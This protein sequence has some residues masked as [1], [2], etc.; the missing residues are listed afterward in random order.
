MGKIASGEVRICGMPQTFATEVAVGRLRFFGSGERSGERCIVYFGSE[1]S[2]REAV[3]LG[4]AYFFNTVAAAVCSLDVPDSLLGALSELGTPYFLLPES[5]SIYHGLE[6]RLALLDG[7][8]GELIIDPQLETLRGYTSSYDGRGRISGA[9]KSRFCK[10]ISE[11][12]AQAGGALCDCDD[13]GRGGELFEN[14]SALAEE[15][16][17]SSLTVLLSAPRDSSEEAEERFCNSAEALFRAAVYGNMSLLIGGICSQNEAR[18]AF[19]L[20]HGCFCRLL[21]EG[22]EFNGYIAKGIL[23]SS[24]VLLLDVSRLPRCDLLC[25]DFSLLSAR[26][27]GADDHGALMRSREELRGFWETWKAQNDTLCRSRELRAICRAADA[28]AFFFDWVDFM[29][30]S[31]VYL[32]DSDNGGFWEGS[33]KNS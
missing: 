5:F 12:R 26:L 3:S 16:C 4:G 15:L 17:T 24:P 22:R 14:A 6:G 23:I 29:N 9:K 2:L 8:K 19:E 10:D 28:D 18:R 20:L 31:E 21:E 1:K 13:I 33:V 32:D 11:L 7:R 25:L 27:T 30:I